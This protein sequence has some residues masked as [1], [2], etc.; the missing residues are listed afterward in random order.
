MATDGYPLRADRCLG[1]TQSSAAC[2]RLIRS[3]IAGAGR[4]GVPGSRL[5][6]NPPG[7]AIAAGNAP[8]YESRSATGHRVDLRANDARLDPFAHRRRQIARRDDP[9]R[10]RRAVDEEQVVDKVG[11]GDGEPALVQTA[12]STRSQP[13]RRIP[14]GNGHQR[15]RGVATTTPPSTSAK[16]TTR[17]SRSNCCRTDAGGCGRRRSQGTTGLLSPARAA[18]SDASPMRPTRPTGDCARRRSRSG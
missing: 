10:D 16:E 15:P 12:L 6:A 17:S 3:V 4:L 2:S 18:G 1:V 5:Q 11:L 13:M 7:H 8:S 9:G 14:P